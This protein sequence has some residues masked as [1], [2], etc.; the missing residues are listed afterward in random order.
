LSLASEAECYAFL[1]L[2]W[3]PSSE[4]ITRERLNGPKCSA[5][6]ASS[7]LPDIVIMDE[8]LGIPGLRAYNRCLRRPDLGYFN[9][10]RLTKVFRQFH[11][12]YK[13]EKTFRMTT[14][15]TSV[16]NGHHTSNGYHSG[17]NVQAVKPVQPKGNGLDL[18][19]LGMNSGTCLDGID[20]ALVRYRQETPEAP[21]HMELLYVSRS[22]NYVHMY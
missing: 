1:P 14:T 4:P 13:H 18:T 17:D 10:Y 8:A 9:T 5:K 3:A 7:R 15:Q 20:C 6:G 19:V 16:M 21:L 2:C 12:K 11:S 22:R